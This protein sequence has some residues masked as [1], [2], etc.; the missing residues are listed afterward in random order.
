[1][2][3]SALWSLD[4]LLLALFFTDAT[5]REAGKVVAAV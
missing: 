3:K 5:I 4:L 2:E 1:M